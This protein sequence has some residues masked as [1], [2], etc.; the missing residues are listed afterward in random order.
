MARIGTVLAIVLLLGF[1]TFPFLSGFAAPFVPNSVQNPIGAQMIESTAMEA[2]L[3]NGKEGKA[4]LEKLAT[5]LAS[6]SGSDHTFKIYV[7]KADVLNAFAAPGGHVVLFKAIIDNAKGP[8][9]VAGVLGH[10]MGHVV[11]DHPAKGV[12]EALGYGVFGL[13]VPGGSTDTKAVAQTM[14]TSAHSRGD[15]LDADRVGVE[16]L[17]N[18]GIDSHGLI[19]FFATLEAQGN[20]IPGALEFLS[21][22]PTGETRTSRLQEH[23][24]DGEV[25]MTDAEWEA[26]KTICESAGGSADPIVVSG[27]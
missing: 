25:A 4:A 2:P 3:C 24:A 16:M 18:A 12:V 14:L 6:A 21:T 8:N 26:L 27:S 22:H 15:E 11:E 9:E 10:E 13:L 19:D 20:A 1:V 7:A 23:V 17:N 5:K